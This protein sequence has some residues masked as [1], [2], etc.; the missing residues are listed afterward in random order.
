[1]TDHLD[2]LGVIPARWASKRFPGKPLAMLKGKPLIQWVWERAFQVYG[3]SE[4]LVATDDSRIKDVVRQ[5][6]G[7]AVMTSSGHASGTDRIAEVCRDR[8]EQIIVNIQG[9]EPLLD[10]K[11]VEQ[12]IVALNSDDA[13]AVGTAAFPIRSLEE[14]DD[15][16]VV[17]VSLDRSHRALMFSRSA[18][19]Y[20]REQQDRRCWIDLGIHYRHLGVYV[21]RR[22]ALFDFCRWKP[23]PLE[24]AEKLEQ[25]R[26]LEHGI[27]IICALVDKGSPGVDTPED[28][29]QLIKMIP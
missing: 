19:P 9:D 26:F 15:P 11:A 4:W 16:N 14:L 18:I 22:E 24:Q 17:K 20:V 13:A 6:G 25:L 8:S 1:M 28:L 5:F 3:V 2:I 21:Y 29:N 7:T 23:G 27:P 10:P 12:M